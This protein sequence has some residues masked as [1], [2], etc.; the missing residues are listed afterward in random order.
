YIAEHL[1]PTGKAAIIVPEGIVFQSANAYKSLRKFLVE[2]NL[3]YAVISLPSGV[4][5]PY[6]GVKTSIL[7]FDRTI[8]K[9]KKEILFVSIENDGYGLGAQRRKVYGSDIPEVKELLK[10]YKE[11]KDIALSPLATI[12]KKVDIAKLDYILVGDRYKESVIASSEF[13]LVELG[14]IIKLNFGTRITKKDD[15]G[16]I[17]PVYGGG[18]NSFY[19][20]T[21]NR[22]NEYVI[23]RFALG[24]H[25]V[26]YVDGKFFML[27]SGFTFDIEDS[28]KDKIDKTY[29][30][31]ILLN[32][33]DTIY[34]CSRG[35][36]QKNL[37]IQSFKQIKI[38]IPSLH[39]QKEI[40][41]EIEEYQK[42]IDGARQVVQNYKPKIKILPGWE[43]KLLKEMVNIKTGKIDSN[44][45]VKNGEYPFFTC[46]KEI[47]YIDE[48][49]FDCEALL[50]AGNNATANYDVKYYKGK[51]NAYQRTYIITIIDTSVIDYQYLKYI[52]ESNLKL[53]KQNSVGSQTKY[54]TLG[55]IQSLIIPIPSMDEQRMIVSEIEEEISL[56]QKN[57][58]LIDIF[59]KKI[60]D[61]ISEVWGD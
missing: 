54:L 23:A 7:L 56:V 33:Q 3:L 8:A 51:F 50:L 5:N 59:E 9:Q 43:S 1:N 49:A 52:L 19:T 34:S 32:M 2:D 30:G 41:K 26:R 40:V 10:Q 25:C 45:A 55:V 14:E 27:D 37:D 58:R 61:I 29:V 57:D 53:L 47:Y 11:G 35:H 28:Y 24:E 31:N 39:V 48:F 21:S 17:Y 42:V 12:A 15:E 38:P 22:E 4:F 36:A 60:K 13:E 6:S 16:T 18:G 20:D 44:R 46:A